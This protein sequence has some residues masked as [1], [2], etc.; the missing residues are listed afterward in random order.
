MNTPSFRAPAPA[1]RLTLDGCTVVTMDAAGTEHR[2]GHVVIEGSRITAVGAGPAPEAAGRDGAARVVD[3]RG[4]V[5]TPGLVNCHHHLYQ[6]VT[7]GLAVDDTLFGWLTT[8][9]PV[10][11]GLDED[12]VRS[13]ATAGLGWL[14]RTGCTTS[15]DHHY[16]FPEA[17]GDLLA[18]EVDAARRVGLRFLPTRGSMDL[19]RS[20]GGLPPDH[21]VEDL[22]T[23]LTASAEAVD[24][25]HDPSPDSM[26]RI[27]LAPCSPFSVTGELLKQAALLARDKGVRL[28]THLAETLDEQDYCREHF[29]CSPVE[30]VESLGW[31]GDDV[32]LAHGI[33]LDDRAIGTL[34]ATGTGV[35]HCPSSNARLGA[36]ICRSRELRDAGVPVGLG[37]DGAASNE[38]ASLLEEARHALLFARAAGGPQALSTRDALR[39]ATIDGARALGWDDQ[40]GSLEP[41]KLAD[42]AVWRVDTLPHVDIAD[43]VAGLVLGSPPPLE[44]LLVGGRSV[45]ERDRLVTLEEEAVARDAAD[46]SRRLLDRA[47]GH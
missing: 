47:A 42:L 4:C 41:G 5:V 46:A 9:Y 45:V 38:S 18:A 44:L 11:A 35:A 39:M 43:P 40:I 29:G 8:L 14:A 37:V 10:W 24:R 25:Y 22:D 16:V 30:Y 21:V 28:H 36:G 3:A 6:W 27:G 20:Q 33:H 17:G 15:M 2:S 12:I 23:I 7:R 19:G 26:L 31:L 34:G 32:W 1:G 13:A